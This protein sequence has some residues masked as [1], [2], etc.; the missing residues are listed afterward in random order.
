MIRHGEFASDL[1][2]IGGTNSVGDLLINR[3]RERVENVR[4]DVIECFSALI[5]R[6]SANAL[7][8]ETPADA[9]STID[10]VDAAP[11]TSVT[12]ADTAESAHIQFFSSHTAVIAKKCKLLF[13]ANR[14]GSASAD[15]AKTRV[16]A[17]GVIRLLTMAMQVIMCYPHFEY[18]DYYLFNT[19]RV[20]SIF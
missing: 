17:L 1:T 10:V 19:S 5:R 2:L 14:K 9:M 6:F 11:T 16:A 3:F 18:I 15:D 7:S 20:M 13:A 12:V 4:L 8:D